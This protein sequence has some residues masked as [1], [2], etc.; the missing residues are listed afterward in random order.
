VPLFLVLTKK[1]VVVGI[2]IRNL[3]VVVAAVVRV[4]LLPVL[5]MKLFVQILVGQRI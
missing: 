5:I 4:K 1:A 2:K 3:V